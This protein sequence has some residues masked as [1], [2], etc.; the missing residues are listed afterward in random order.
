[1]MGLISFILIIIVLTKVLQGGFAPKDSIFLLLLV[2]VGFTLLPLATLLLSSLK[3]RRLLDY[4]GIGM[5]GG[6]AVAVLLV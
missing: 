2:L 5:I 1:M 4:L 6:Y 3:I